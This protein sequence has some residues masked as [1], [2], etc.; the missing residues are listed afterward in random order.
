MI[1]L[2]IS[3]YMNAWSSTW[4]K[5]KKKYFYLEKEMLVFILQPNYPLSYSQKT[6]LHISELN[7]AHSLVL[8]I[9][10]RVFV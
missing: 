8:Y 5:K 1:F 3:S 10:N 7:L 9:K 2:G 6:S 4:L